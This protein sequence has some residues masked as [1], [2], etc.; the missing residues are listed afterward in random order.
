MADQKYDD[1]TRE[2]LMRNRI[3]FMED[4]TTVRK[5]AE[6][7][8][9]N[10]AGIPNLLVREMPFLEGKN[11]KAFVLASNR[12]ADEASN[13]AMQPHMFVR[14]K[15]DAMTIAH[16]AEHLL[17]R[18]NS[19]FAQGPRDTF[20]RL[21]K[22]GGAEPYILRSQFLNGLTESLPYLEK[23]YGIKGGYMDKDFI[24]D[25][26]DIGL[27]ELFATLAGAEAALGVD[28][29]KDPELRKT[30][31]KNKNVREA[32]NAVTGLRQTRLDPRDIPPYTRVP[33]KESGGVADKLKSL[34]AL[35][36]GGYVEHAGNHKLI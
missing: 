7:L 19:G 16:E 8:P 24:R 4:N 18:Q 23:K 1:R 9:Y 14:P 26:G 17:A 28:L 30:M 15:A 20:N 21:L 22:D 35:A 6:A 2:L 25:E 34:L 33:E 31:F 27:Y 5:S 13:R 10:T 3:P 11:T 12:L 32:Y 29:T 36:D